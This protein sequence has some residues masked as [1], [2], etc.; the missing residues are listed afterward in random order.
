MVSEAPLRVELIGARKED[1]T[2][3]EN[4]ETN[5]DKYYTYF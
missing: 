2:N 4:N 1:Q 3:S 5:S